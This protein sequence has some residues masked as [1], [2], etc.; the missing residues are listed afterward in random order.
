MELKE[1]RTYAN[2]MSAFAGES[3]A[4]VKYGIYGEKAREEG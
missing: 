2:L 3:Q 1:S 4:R